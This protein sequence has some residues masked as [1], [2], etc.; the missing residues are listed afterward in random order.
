MTLPDLAGEYRSRCAAWSDIREYLPLLHGYAR[1]YS[2]ARII[3]AGVRDGNSTIA[4]LHAAEITGGHLWS[5]DCDPVLERPGG[6]GPWA[7]HP[8][9]TFTQG[10]A[11][12]PG[13]LE[14]QPAQADVFFLDASHRYDDT[15]AELRAYMPRLV[16]GGTALFHDTRYGHRA[17]SGT[18]PVTAA[19]DVY[20]AEAGLS[21]TDLP[22]QYGMG[23]IIRDW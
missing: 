6:M 17:A 23:V 12:D 10:R 21:W 18:W 5:V 16:P 3:E 11:A 19:L 13:T 22:G 2:G 7:G 8:A 15:L 9:W 1:M 20:C 14:E 4:L